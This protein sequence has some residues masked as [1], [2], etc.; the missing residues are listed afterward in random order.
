MIIFLL[1]N[2]NFVYML[3]CYY[4]SFTVHL[5]LQID[6]IYSIKWTVLHLNPTFKDFI[7]VQRSPTASTCLD[8]NKTFDMKRVIKN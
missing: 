5:I 1:Y 8:G 4:D 6:S 3:T 2:F 7:I